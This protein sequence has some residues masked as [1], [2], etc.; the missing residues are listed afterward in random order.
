MHRPAHVVVAR[1]V[2][3]A[4]ASRSRWRAWIVAVPL[5]LLMLG[6]PGSATAAAYLRTGH[7]DEQCQ[8]SGELCQPP[9]PLGLIATSNVQITVTASPEHCSDVQFYM[10][11]DGTP[12]AATGFLAP[13]QSATVTVLIPPSRYL[14]PHDLD[15]Q[16]EGRL[17]GCN[18]GTLIAWH[19]DATVVW[20]GQPLTKRQKDL[21]G[22]CASAAGASGLPITA[23]GGV[24]LF[25]PVLQPVGVGL[26]I[27]GLGV[28]AFGVWCDDQAHDPPR[29]DFT[30]VAEPRSVRLPRVRP[31]HGVSRRAATAMN[32]VDKNDARLAE[33]LRPFTLSVDR[34]EGALAAQAPQYVTLQ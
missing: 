27:V 6:G 30:V 26:V 7:I 10:L 12:S 18:G 19:A 2:R 8:S 13:G 23:I 22:G 5:A 34:Y 31:G 24:A 20:D 1:C 16:A 15:I 11:V 9:A 17:G 3:P 4:Y 33:L 32:A 28:N 21:F 25:V 14:N 29:S